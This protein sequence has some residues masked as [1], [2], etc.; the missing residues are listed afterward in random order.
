MKNVPRRKREWPA[1]IA[2]VLTLV[3]LLVA[4]VC[5]PLC[6]AQNCMRTH[7]P[8]ASKT[9][10]HGEMVVNKDGSQIHGMLNCNS[11]ELP[12][13]ALLA[14]NKSDISQTSQPASPAVGPN[15]ITAES[16]LILAVPPGSRGPSTGTLRYFSDFLAIG[17]LRI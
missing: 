6:A 4:P 8:A 11:S 15:A 7:A 12:T 17:V 3:A 2:S 9:R 1:A 16:I 13:A 14:G 10:C 5:A